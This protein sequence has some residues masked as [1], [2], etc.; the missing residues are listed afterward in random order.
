MTTTSMIHERM[1]VALTKKM[2][3]HERASGADKGHTAI[4][5]AIGISDDTLRTFMRGILEPGPKVTFKIKQYLNG[6]Y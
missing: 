1:R 6:E 2:E 3:E 5:K 4:A